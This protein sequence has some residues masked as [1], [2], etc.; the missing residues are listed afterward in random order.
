ME[1]NSKKQI[2]LRLSPDL[3]AEIAKWADEDYRSVNSQ[4]EYLLSESVRAHKR[5]QIPPSTGFDHLVGVHGVAR[6]NLRPAGRASIDGTNYDVLT[7][8]DF[9]TAGT[10][11]VVI[12]VQ[13]NRITVMAAGKYE[14]E[15]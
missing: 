5:A 1:N 12:D 10:E 4:I 2:P 15:E 8:G 9:V 11:V 3:Y 7:E 6:S 14:V 13:G